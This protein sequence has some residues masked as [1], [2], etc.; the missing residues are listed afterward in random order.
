M[1]ASIGPN[2]TGHP[3][4][5]GHPGVAGHPMGPGM[6]PNAG[7]PGTPGAGM[8]NQFPGGPMAAQ[9]VN[10]AMMGGMPPGANPNVHALQHLNPAQQQM[11]QQQ[12]QQMQHCKF[13]TLQTVP[14]VWNSFR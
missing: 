3:A 13:S 2:F 4:G 6:A 8:P 12:Q 14:Q 1:A 9:Q 7:Q 5:M 10:A 11:F